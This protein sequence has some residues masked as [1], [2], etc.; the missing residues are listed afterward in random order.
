MYVITSNLSKCCS[1]NLLSK[2]A[3][4]S[5]SVIFLDEQTDCQ[6]GLFKVQ[7]HGMYGQHISA[8]N[9]RNEKQTEAHW[10]AMAS[11]LKYK[12][13]LFVEWT[14][15][16]L[17]LITSEP[18]LCCF[19]KKKTELHFVKLL[20]N[21]PLWVLNI[22]LKVIASDQTKLN[23]RVFFDSHQVQKCDHHVYYYVIM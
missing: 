3:D 10:W 17:N 4:V 1:S 18:L 21:L 22:F 12:V 16:G 15:L 9:V 14:D 23:L 2:M 13:D 11:T 7:G 5:Y 8:D 19:D 6:E 20:K